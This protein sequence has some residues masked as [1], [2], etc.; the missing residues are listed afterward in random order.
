LAAIN[1]FIRI[2]LPSTEISRHAKYVLTDN[3]QRP[4]KRIM[5]DRPDGRTTGPHNASLRLL[6][7]AEL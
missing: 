4:D 2:S 7:A 1:N 3:G 6:L 5:T